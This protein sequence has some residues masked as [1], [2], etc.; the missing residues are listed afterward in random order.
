M[1]DEKVEKKVEKSNAV[2]EKGSK[3]KL[4][5]GA[6]SF[7]AKIV[8]FLL[9]PAMIMVFLNS[10]KL[11]KQIVDLDRKVTSLQASEKDIGKKVLALEDEFVVL[12]L[13]RRLAKVKNSVKSLLNLQ[14]L[15]AD[16]QELA[17]KIQG[18][19]DDLGVE[20][21]K[22]E[23]EIGGTISKVFQSSR[24]CQKPCYQRCPEP[25]LIMHPPISQTKGATPALTQAATAH[26]K[27]H[28]APKA[29]TLATGA[30][31][32]SKWSKFIRLRIFG[33]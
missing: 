10:Q 12:S 26:A 30:N 15:M 4:D 28:A 32:N 23:Q 9:V 24:P 16:N 7:I 25:V 13:K 14:G 29:K 19:V 21:R 3:K 5:G 11:H 20:E 33:N 1:S 17:T 8:V 31:P 18:L 22:L 2:P 27:A 6:F